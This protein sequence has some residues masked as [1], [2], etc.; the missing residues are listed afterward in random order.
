M[1]YKRT[2]ISVSEENMTNSNTGLFVAVRIIIAMVNILIAR[3]SFIST[4]VV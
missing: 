4:S 3:I 1:V 2:I